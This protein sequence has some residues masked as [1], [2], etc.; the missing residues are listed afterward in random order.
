MATIRH[1]HLAL[2]AATEPHAKPRSTLLFMFLGVSAICLMT[3]FSL[4][5]AAVYIH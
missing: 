3:S 1:S 4:L 5:A 2:N